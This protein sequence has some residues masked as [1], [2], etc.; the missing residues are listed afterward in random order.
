M[1]RSHPIRTTANLLENSLNGYLYTV[2]WWEMIVASGL[3]I[4]LRL[5]GIGYNLRNNELP[6]TKEMWRML[7]EK[8]KA[9]TQGWVALSQASLKP[10]PQWKGGMATTDLL[11][12]QLR[13]QRAVL[14]AAF[15]FWKPFH[16]AS[17]ANALRLS[18]VGRSKSP[19]A[20]ASREK[21]N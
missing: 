15:G 11:N 16:S 10:W 7:E 17:T 2:R 12:Y 19:K 21:H 18:R 1:A 8:N 6:D 14:D 5:S 3:T 4:G 20:R 9:A 13:L